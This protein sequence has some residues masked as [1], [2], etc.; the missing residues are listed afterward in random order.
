[1]V[2]EAAVAASVAQQN[3]VLDV[4]GW[5][6][7]GRSFERFQL[8]LFSKEGKV[9]AEQFLNDEKRLVLIADGRKVWRYDPVANEYTFLDQP[10]TFA[11]TM[12]VVAGWSRLHLQ[13]PLRMMGGSVR[14]LVN[15][16]FEVNDSWVR[17]FQTRPLTGGDWRGSDTKFF[18]DDKRRIEKLTVEDRQDTPTGLKHVWFEGILAYPDT[19]TVKFDFVPPRGAKPAADLPVRIPGDGG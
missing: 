12:S 19:L 13:R 4:G 11:K 9:Y 8:R 3:I 10:D 17:V 14:W 1:M 2:I 15:P 5:Q 16:Q 7:Y 6:R 18:F